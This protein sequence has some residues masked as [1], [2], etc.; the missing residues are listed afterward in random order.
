MRQLLDLEPFWQH[1]PHFFVT[2]DTALGRSV[3]RQFEA[4]FLPHFALGQARLGKTSKMIRAAFKSFFQAFT[5]VR[6]R[7]PDVV[8]TTGAGSQIFVVL[9][10]R[11]L[12]A[13]IILIDSFARFDRPSMF[14]R[15]AGPLAHHR[16][17]QSAASAANWK[18]AIAFDPLRILDTPRPAKSP[19]LLAT[20]G[21]TLPFPR[22]VQLVLE[23]KRDGTISEEVVLQVCQDISDLPEVEGVSVVSDLS[24]D[25]IKE[26]LVRADLVVCHGGTG[27]II[28]AL[29]QHCRVVVVPRRFELGEHYD[30]HQQEITTS[31]EGRGYVC[32]AHDAPSLRT[33]LT[34]IREKNPVAVTTDYHA[35]IAALRDL[36]D[37]VSVKAP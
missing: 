34:A 10:A 8:I 22:L 30:D 32:S 24:F 5:I 26:L 28:T 23:A 37:D 18:G 21:A 4:E 12:G 11:L 36:I 33:A 16:F 13:K 35:L 1:Y 15:L 9:W 7:K 25:D 3:G 19:L 2:E 29:R 14:A 6:R 17:A 20:V 27:S 31:F